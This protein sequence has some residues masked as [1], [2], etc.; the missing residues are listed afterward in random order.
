M[1]HEIIINF[2]SE[3]FFIC[4][5]FVVVVAVVIDYVLR[6]QPAEKSV[7]LCDSCDFFDAPACLKHKK[8]FQNGYEA[9]IFSDGECR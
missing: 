2:L 4:I 6:K 9:K 5:F 8:R 1:K 3:L 7:V